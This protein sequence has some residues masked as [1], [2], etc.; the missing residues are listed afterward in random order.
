[1][2]SLLTYTASFVLK[3]A[4]VCKESTSWYSSVYRRQFARSIPKYGWPKVG[5]CCMTV[6]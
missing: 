3:D 2:K 6:P 4:T 5:C 1:M